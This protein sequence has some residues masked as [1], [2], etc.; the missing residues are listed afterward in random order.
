MAVKVT[1]SDVANNA[2]AAPAL[3]AYIRNFVVVEPVAESQTLADPL[4]TV[5]LVAGVAVLRNTLSTL[6]AELPAPS[7]VFPNVAIM[8]SLP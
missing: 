7:V 6:D 4:V 1:S 8:N 2:P 5:P 3:S